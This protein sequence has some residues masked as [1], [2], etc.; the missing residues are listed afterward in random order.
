MKTI[1]K[2][3]KTELKTLFFSP[4]AWLIIVIFA[5]QTGLV[6]TGIYDQMLRRQLIGWKLWMA[7][8][9]TFGG[10]QGT[11]TIVQQYLFLYIPLL[12]MGV[13]S[14]E[15]S[16]GS[17]KLLYSSPL[18]SRQIVLGKYLALVIYAFVLIG[19]LS[20]YGIYAAFTIHSVDI[21]VILTG[22]LGLFLLTCAYAAVGLFMSSLTSYTVVSAM[23]TLAIFAVL[24]YVKTVGQDIEFVRDI[25][26]W[27]AISGRC[28]TFI[29]GMITSEDVLYFLIVISL[30]IGFT[31]I[32]MLSGRQ[33]KPWY[34][35]FGRYALVFCAA[36][37]LGYFSAKPKLM[38]Y[39]DAT[40]TKFNTL[41]K[42][43]QEVLSHLDDE[44]TITTY[45][46]ML[47]EN[48][49]IAVPESYKY[50]V[51]RFK[52]YIRFKPGI[53]LKYKYYYHK[54]GNKQL[55]KQYPTLNDDQLIDTLVKLYDWR[56]GIDPYKKINKEVDLEP[57]RFRFVRSL[58][59]ANGKETFLRIY[60][61]MMRL[62]SETE[63]TAAFKR[64]VIDQLP[65]V[66]FLTGH[67]ERRSD[68]EEDRGY[69]MFAQE[70]SFRLAL[71]NQGFDFADVTLDKE[72]PDNIRILLIAEARKPISPEEMKRL[73]HYIERGGNLII[74]GEPGRQEFMNPIVEP[75]G[76]K[77]LPGMLVK[78][79]KKFQSNLLLLTPTK[80][81]EDFSFHFKNIKRQEQLLPMLTTTA[82]QFST[83][84]GFK[85]T[86]LFTSD[87]TGGWLEQ[88]TT[89]FIDDTARLNPAAGEV[90]QPYPT[91][92]ALSRKVNNKEQKIIVMGDADC[93]SNGEFQMMRKDISSANINF[94]SGMFFWLT[95]EE[96]PIDMR[97][98]NAPDRSLRLTKTSWAV[99]KVGLKWVFPA[100][101]MVCGLYIWVRRKRR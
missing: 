45:T 99:S 23:G 95:D 100:I 83:D 1:Y 93:L 11:F 92:I 19:V 27:L 72:I 80:A 15:F 87:T 18:T 88:E 39:Y 91:V 82:L 25:T 61:D 57:E 37:L 47:D 78:P 3:A 76:V 79:S 20:I 40:R 14:R 44:L 51:D 58:K 12:T 22:L 35:S 33:R 81:A 84:K 24:S 67:G 16:S 7:T 74:A 63:I 13:M 26:Y 2:I 89:N 36:M 85:V 48:Y 38:S 50:D 94:V 53:R 77:F 62:P 52:Q 54:A 28:D 55:E 75:L 42:S 86:T 59:R 96:L 65:T 90:E 60:D 64:L 17:I 8:L 32:K 9:G 5:F 41:T 68:A 73:N 34:V 49:W 46:N 31:I 10:I 21:P 70:K 98:P 29:S 56:F 101:L 71:I 6:F 97:R 4:I 43:S 69:N 66:G 30:F